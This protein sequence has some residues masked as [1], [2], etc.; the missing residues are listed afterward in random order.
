MKITQIMVCLFCIG[1]G[2]L[3][4]GYTGLVEREGFLNA[5]GTPA[6]RCGIDLPTCA[7]GMK[8]V[9]GFCS[10]TALPALLVNQLPVLP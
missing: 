2:A 3:I 5:R 1:V 10:G 8:C 7:L 6:V 9:N 4:M